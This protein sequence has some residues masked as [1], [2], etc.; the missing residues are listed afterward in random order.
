MAIILGPLYPFALIFGR[1]IDNNESLHSCK[2][3][4][5]DAQ[6]ATTLLSFLGCAAILCL[7]HRADF[8]L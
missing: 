3:G 2:D 4:C 7:A 8:T 6:R 1:I 5:T